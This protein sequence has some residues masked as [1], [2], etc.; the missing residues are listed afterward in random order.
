MAVAKKLSPTMLRAI[1][2]AQQNGNKLYRHSGGF[3]AGKSFSEEHSRNPDG[4]PTSED[5]NTVHA[6][7]TRGVAEYTDHRTNARGSFE[8]EITLKAE[9][10]KNG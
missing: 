5:T 6:L 8:V 9:Y 7:V 4:T 2:L 3:W 1:D 10:R